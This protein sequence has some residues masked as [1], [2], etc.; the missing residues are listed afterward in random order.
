MAQ[1]IHIKDKV[2]FLKF[3][4]R[5]EDNVLKECIF[6]KEQKDKDGKETGKVEIKIASAFSLLE[7]REELAKIK[8]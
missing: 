3:Y 8:D 4:E 1:K 6:W 7:V 2:D 5:V